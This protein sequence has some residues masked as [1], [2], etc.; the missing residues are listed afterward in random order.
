MTFTQKPGAGPDKRA[1]LIAIKEGARQGRKLEKSGSL[2]SSP[3]AGR[4]K[5]TTRSRWIFHASS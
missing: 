2:L 5:Q 4:A 1:Q 3:S